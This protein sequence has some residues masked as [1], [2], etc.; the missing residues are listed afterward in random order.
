MQRATHKDSNIHLP[1]KP[2]LMPELV[3]KRR[4]HPFNFASKPIAEP[5]KRWAYMAHNKVGGQLQLTVAIIATAITAKQSVVK[6]KLIYVPQ[7]DSCPP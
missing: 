2:V 6:L 1:S 5:I 3:T 7:H 4:H